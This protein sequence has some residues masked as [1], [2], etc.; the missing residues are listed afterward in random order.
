MLLQ[1][2]SKCISTIKVFTMLFFLLFFFQDISM[3]WNFL[4]ILF[5]IFFSRGYGLAIGFLKIGFKKLYV[6][7]LKGELHEREPL[8]VLDFYISE[9]YQRQSY[10]KKLY[11]YMLMVGCYSFSS[12]IFFYLL[13]F[14]L[15]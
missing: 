12:I 4:A 11:D 8:C 13:P 9:P 2:A 7:D 3:T 1:C 15:D 14:I 6:Y 5:C 10:G